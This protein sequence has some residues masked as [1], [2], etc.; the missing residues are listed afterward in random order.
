MRKL[1]RGTIRRRRGTVLALTGALMPVL[2]GLVA[3]SLDPGVV[4]VA[5]NQL[6]TAADAAALAGAGELA[7]ARYASPTGTIGVLDINNARVQAILAAKNNYILNSSQGVV[8]L[9]SDV[10]VGPPPSLSTAD[11]NLFNTVTVTASCDGTRNPR[12]PSFFGQLWGATPTTLQLTSAATAQPCQV[13]GFRSVNN[14]NANLL[15][16]VLDLPT[17]RAM[18]EGQTTDQYTYNAATGTVTSGPD[19]ITESQLYPVKNGDPGNWGTIDIGVN[20]NSTSILGDQIRYG[21]TPIQLATF[22]NG[23]ISLDQADNSTSP[24][25]PYHVFNGNPGISAGLKDDLASIVGRPVRIPI[26]DQTGGNGNNA[27]YRVVKFVGVRILSVNFRGNPKY[28]IVQP[29]QVKD[30]TATMK[31]VPQQF[32]DPSQDWRGWNPGDPIVLHL[33]R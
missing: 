26:Y 6:S 7:R 33:T 1:I 9:D 32:P 20:N 24:P 16:I 30:A 29:A 2:V 5:R 4:A 10:T 23:T 28:V 13:S 17:Y 19:G 8:L 22:P 11:V 12:V 31:P 18:V 21:I 3:V 14:F 15:P 25:T 27:W